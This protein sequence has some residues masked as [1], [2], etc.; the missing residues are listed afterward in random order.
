MFDRLANKN[1]LPLCI[2]ILLGVGGVISSAFL[3]FYLFDIG[4][5]DDNV[6]SDGII[7]GIIAA[8]IAI[9]L[10][11]IKLPNIIID[12][13]I[14]H[15]SFVF[16]A[17]G[18]FLFIFGTVAYYD[19]LLGYHNSRW[20]LPLSLL[21]ITIFTYPLYRMSLDRFVSILAILITTFWNLTRYDFFG[22]YCDIFIIVQ[23]L[24]VGFLFLSKKQIKF[25]MPMAYAIIFALSYE[26][27]QISLPDRL[28]IYV[29]IGTIGYLLNK[30]FMIFALILLVYFIAKSH[31]LH[32]DE[33]FIIIYLGIIIL[34]A[35]SSTGVIFAIALLVL[36]YH[37][38]DK[39]LLILGTLFIPVFLYLYYHNLNVILLNKS[40]IL[41]SSG[42]LLLLA[43]QYLKYR[44]WDREVA[45]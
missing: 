30:A 18:K 10:H 21:F 13:I 32:L 43:R 45:L 37:N 31:K 23:I 20:A 25:L 38:Q 4:F 9:V 26:I 14:M 39:I 44:K 40:I 28:E 24:I 8:S 29:S 16:M 42:A 36:G 27:M 6:P 5:L 22:L 35:V 34:G 41:V 3:I 7:Y 2:S 1:E 19:S 15:L 12:S 11:Y 17:G 33:K